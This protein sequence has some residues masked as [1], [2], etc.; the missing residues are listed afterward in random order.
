MRNLL[1]S[2]D[3]EAFI[4][5]I[6][7]LTADHPRQWGKMTIDQMLHHLSMPIKVALGEMTMPADGNVFPRSLIKWIILRLK[8]FPRG[9]APTS[10]GMKAEGIFDFEMKK[11]ELIRLVEDLGKKTQ[12]SKWGSH[13]FFGKMSAKQWGRLSHTHLNHHLMQFKA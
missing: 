12:S 11:A 9:K 1:D 8:T 3:R 7:N 13:P 5:R 10:P 4:Q 2:K 6:K